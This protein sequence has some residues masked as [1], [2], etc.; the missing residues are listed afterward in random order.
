[1]EFNEALLKIS[2]QCSN[3]DDGVRYC[4]F[5]GHC[6]NVRKFDITDH[7]DD[8]PIKVIANKLRLITNI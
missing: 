6:I 2:N 8:C 4:D 7:T 5:C 1:M 3:Y